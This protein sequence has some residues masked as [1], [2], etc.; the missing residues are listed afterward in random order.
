MVKNV[1]CLKF[2]YE[3]VDAKPEFVLESELQFTA[4]T[5][6]DQSLLER[7][8]LV[9]FRATGD[10]EKFKLDCVCRV[11]FSF[12]NEENVIEG[13]ALL[14]KHQQEAYEQ[15]Q[16]LINKALTAVGQNTVALPAINYD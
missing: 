8:I 4:Q 13:K 16:L 3:C 1:D 12:E 14:Q 10:D 9:N 5:P 11:I 7:A 2:K 6:I 15:L